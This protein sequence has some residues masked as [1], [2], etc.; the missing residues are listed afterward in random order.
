MKIEIRNIS[1]TLFYLAD[2][3][4]NNIQKLVSRGMLN[5][6]TIFFQWIENS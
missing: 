2:N 3:L 5:G 4:W 6:E 1:Q